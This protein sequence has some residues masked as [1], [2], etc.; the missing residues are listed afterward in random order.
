[1]R[2]CIALILTI[3]V[4]VRLPAQQRTDVP[5]WV[6]IAPEVA[7]SHLLKKVAPIYPAF[8]KAV[9][10]EGVVRFEI[11]IYPDGHVQRIQVMTRSPFL[12]EAAE[13]AVVQYIYKPFEKDGKPI[14][15]QTTV[16]VAFVIPNHQNIFRPPPPPELT[17][18]NFRNPDGVIPPVHLSAEMRDWL[19]TYWLEM[20]DE[21][22]CADVASRPF[23]LTHP[24]KETSP[25]AI[26]EL[27]A[28]SITLEIQTEN[29][30]SHLY[31]VQPGCGCGATGNCP[32]E[33]IEDRAGHIHVIADSGG[34]GIYVYPRQGRPY[35]DIF[36]VG[37]M[38]GS[39]SDVT[40]YSNVGGE[41]GPLYCGKITW[42]DSGREK[43]DVD[44]CR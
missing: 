13:K 18:D 2:G 27:L 3:L 22:G 9:G 44:V 26:V 40:G 35:P 20:M 7:A 33:L 14:G 11:H 24:P 34:W 42:D 25:K 1:M 21:R 29:P 16:D 10:I 15:V 19:S 12:F 6:D 4:S 5:Q 37:H 30:A 39:E 28:E 36:T 31:V 38:S 17:R 23:A 32:I 43:S 8:A 41:W